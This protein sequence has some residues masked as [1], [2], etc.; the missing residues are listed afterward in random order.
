MMGRKLIL[1]LHL[2]CLENQGIQPQGEYTSGKVL[3]KSLKTHFQNELDPLSLGPGC[4]SARA[5][6][7]RW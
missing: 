1:T 3:G 7:G 6:V 2:L 4:R 5:G